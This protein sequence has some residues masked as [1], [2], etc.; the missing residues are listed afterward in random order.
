MDLAFIAWPRIP[1]QLSHLLVLEI[2]MRMVVSPKFPLTQK[3]GPITQNELRAQAQ[4]IIKDSSSQPTKDQFNVLSGGRHWDVTDFW[5]KKDIILE[6]MGWGA[7]PLHVVEEELEQGELVKLEVEGL[8]QKISL[9]AYLARKKEGQ[10]GPVAQAFWKE[11]IG[12]APL[13]LKNT[14]GEAK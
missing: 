12:L 1:P 4:I 6:G 9:P 10:L 3:K 8:P 11:W 13:R 5:T 2:E 14:P 7:L